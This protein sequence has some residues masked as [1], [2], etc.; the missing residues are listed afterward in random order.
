MISLARDRGRG[1]RF[2]LHAE[3]RVADCQINRARETAVRRALRPASRRPSS[4]CTSQPTLS[5]Q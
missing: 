2:T 1:V 4:P 3:G 5:Q